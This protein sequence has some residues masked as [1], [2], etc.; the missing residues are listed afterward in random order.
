LFLFALETG[1]FMCRPSAEMRILT[2][3]RAL[4]FEHGFAKVSTDLLAREAAVSKAT[5]YRHFDN[6][7]EILRRLTEIETAKISGAQMPVIETR[8]DLERALTEFGV[9]LLTFLN[10]SD[11]VEFGR[12]IHEEARQNPD[13]GQAFFSA[14]FTKTHRTVAQMFAHAGERQ[15]ITLLATP[16]EI[17]EDLIALFK[18]SGMTCAMLCI[19]NVPYTDIDR[20]VQ[21]AVQTILKVYG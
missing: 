19:C 4:F 7:T 16:D 6:M 20:K 12:V 3:A 5:I 21:R 2:A 8:A 10:A 18:G 13:M 1:V 9:R 14:A 11:T 17:A 15:I